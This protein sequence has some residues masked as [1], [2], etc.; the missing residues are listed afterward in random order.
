[1]MPAPEAAKPKTIEEIARPAFVDKKQDAELEKIAIKAKTNSE[2]LNV[3]PTTN[4][5][6]VQSLSSMKYV[7]K[8]LRADNRIA[9]IVQRAVQKFGSQVA[10]F[11]E[12]SPLIEGI[13]FVDRLSIESKEHILFWQVPPSAKVFQDILARNPNANLYVLRSPETDSDDPQ[14]FLKRMFGVIR[15]AVNKREGQIE[16]EKLA[17]AMGASKMSVAL[18]LTVLKRVNLID[19]FSEEGCIY[20]DI[21]GTADKEAEELAEYKQLIGSLNAT[22]EFRAWCAVSKLG[23]L[24]LAV[25]PNHVG[26]PPELSMPGDSESDVLDED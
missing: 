12:S 8:D 14:N 5:S 24:Q 4:D 9:E 21:V 6:R 3:V 19:W 17:A 18:A 15:F 11:A 16:G 10:I 22:R 23:E 13:K 7:F 26:P 20:L 1:M 25:T 2:L